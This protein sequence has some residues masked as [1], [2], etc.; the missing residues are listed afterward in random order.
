MNLHL[1]TFLLLR[2]NVVKASLFRLF[3]RACV[4][5]INIS[6][7]TLM[8]HVHHLPF[9]IFLFRSNNIFLIFLWLLW[10]LMMKNFS[11]LPSVFLAP[12]RIKTIKNF[13]L[14]NIISR[15]I[16][17]LLKKPEGNVIDFHLSFKA[18]GLGLR[19]KRWKKFYFRKIDGKKSRIGAMKHEWANKW[20]F[21]VAHV[22]PMKCDE[23][24]RVRW[25]HPRAETRRMKCFSFSQT[26]IHCLLLKPC[27]R[28]A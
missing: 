14:L 2:K 22:F 5:A 4:E 25:R 10:T 12:T 17:N 20:T 27:L 1:K 7:T 21:S 26:L 9:T 3:P 28:D 24:K 11:G 8:N 19:R 13:P 6:Q 23:S 15:A 18:L 16:L